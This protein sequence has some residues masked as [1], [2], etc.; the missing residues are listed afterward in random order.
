[1]TCKHDNLKHLLLHL[2]QYFSYY[3][4]P[5]IHGLIVTINY[6]VVLR[7]NIMLCYVTLRYISCYVMLHAL[8][9][10]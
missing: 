5:S 2:Q 4:C 9:L 7:Y 8:S 6:H 3:I 10:F 1:M